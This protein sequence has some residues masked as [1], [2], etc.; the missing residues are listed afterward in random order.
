MSVIAAHLKD[1]IESCFGGAETIVQ[2]PQRLV[3]PPAAASAAREHSTTAA[4]QH[5]AFRDR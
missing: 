5:E 2:C 4:I 3:A 1:L